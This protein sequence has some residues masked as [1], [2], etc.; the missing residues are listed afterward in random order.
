MMNSPA[1][2]RLP[3]NFSLK[4]EAH[5]AMMLLAEGIGLEE[6]QFYAITQAGYPHDKLKGKCPNPPLPKA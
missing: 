1:L 5:T 4:S 3:L 2:L 6:R